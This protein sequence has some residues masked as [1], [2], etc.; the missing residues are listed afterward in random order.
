MG[1]LTNQYIVKVL[2][3]KFK[4]ELNTTPRCLLD[5]STKSNRFNTELN[6]KIYRYTSISRPERIQVS[7]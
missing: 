5:I 4:A 7:P 1:K 2:N 3:I 6:L